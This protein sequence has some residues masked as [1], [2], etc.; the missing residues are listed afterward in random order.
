[1]TD[2]TNTPTTPAGP[3][4]AQRPSSPT[5]GEVGTAAGL[6]TRPMTLEVVRT[7]SLREALEALARDLGGD[8]DDGTPTVAV[9]RQRLRDLLARARAGPDD[10]ITAYQVSPD[11]PALRKGD[12]QRT[13]M[14]QTPER[15]AYRCLPLVIAN[16]FGWDVLNPETFVARWNGGRQITDVQVEWL[17][18][19]RGDLVYAH[20]GSG[21][22]TFGL[23]Y[24]FRTPPGIGLLVGGPPNWPRD[25][26]HA[27]LGAVE[28]DWSPATFTMNYLFTRSHHPVVFA[29]GEPY[30]RLIPY[31]RHLAESLRPELRN[32]EADPTLERLYRAWQQERD[33]F[34]RELGNP[35]SEARRRKWQ[36]DYFRAVKDGWPCPPDHQLKL[37]QREFHDLRQEA[38]PAPQG[39]PAPVFTS[40]TRPVDDYLL[41]AGLGFLRTLSD[42]QR[43]R[44][45][46]RFCAR[47]GREQAACSCRR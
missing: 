47:C 45:L 9:P 5:R 16:Q 17:G 22:L 21:L 41:E 30:C 18:P 32:I 19:A 46:A 34:N 40:V 12:R 13:W 6:G 2:W 10:R 35:D 37:E 33:R 7:T 42:E 20:F 23:H 15:F 1:M 14:D 38:P 28:T 29:A 25:G 39:V 26:V 36:K 3:F 8:W 44:L 31:D 43:A 11:P 27:L 24:L 4:S